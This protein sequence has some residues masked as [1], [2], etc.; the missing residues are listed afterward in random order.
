[1]EIANW[2]QST[3][4]SNIDKYKIGSKLKGINL[5]LGSRDLI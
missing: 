2:G 4:V 1:M 3:I 5:W